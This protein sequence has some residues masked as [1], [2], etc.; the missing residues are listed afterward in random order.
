NGDDVLLVE[1]EHS[2]GHVAVNQHEVDA[3]YV[4]LLVRPRKLKAKQLIDGG[5]QYRFPSADVV[6]QSL[7]CHTAAARQVVDVKSIVP[8]LGQQL[9]RHRP[10]DGALA[11][12]LLP[13]TAASASDI[14]RDWRQVKR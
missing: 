8:V 10:D 1:I 2:C 5:R 11:V 14:D 3:G 9:A 7:H 12:R 13:A 6:V 4:A